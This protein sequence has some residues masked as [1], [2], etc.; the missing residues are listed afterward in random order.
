MKKIIFI[1][2][3]ILTIN[4]N[5]QE[6]TGKSYLTIVN[7]IE[8]SEVTSSQKYLVSK[9]VKFSI[10]AIKGDSI[11][12]SFWS[13]SNPEHNESHTKKD[14]SGTLKKD[15]VNAIL[16]RGRNKLRMEDINIKLNLQYKYIGYWSNYLQFRMSL[17]D[18]NDKTV[19][20]YGSSNNFTYGVMTLPIKVR[21]GNG[22][23]RYF[24]FEENLNL[25]FTFGYQRQ[26]HSRVKQSFNILG[27]VGIS[28]VTFN[29]DDRP[30]PTS[31][32]ETAAALMLSI[33]SLYQY[34]TFQVGVFFG[35][36]LI[37]GSTGNKWDFQGKPWL[38]IAIGVSLFTNS[39]EKTSDSLEQ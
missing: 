20:Y 14:D 30:D 18:L 8:V 15:T 19:E 25:G 2:L 7:N 11:L 16:K 26:I 29:E 23:E 39:K 5:A 37:P 33:G 28:R 32:E 34:E 35:T 13:F 9:G 24:D 21:F 10:D 12:V 22:K 3:I 27:G 6:I 1:L 31:T 4:A 36:D 17:G 38:G